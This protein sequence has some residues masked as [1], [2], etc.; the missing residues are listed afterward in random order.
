MLGSEECIPEEGS[1][2]DLGPTAGAML[3]FELPLEALENRPLVLHIGTSL[4]L[5]EQ[6]RVELDL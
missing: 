5:S 1:L 6:G 4:P 3:L 2:A